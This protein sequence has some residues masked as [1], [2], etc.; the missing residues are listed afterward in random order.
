MFSTTLVIIIFTVVIQG[1]ATIPLLH[2]LKI[3]I[4]VNYA[5]VT[6][7]RNA[8]YE[9]KFLQFDNKY[10]QP[11]FTNKKYSPPSDANTTLELSVLN[12]TRPDSASSGTNT[13]LDISVE[14]PEMG[15]VH[16]EDQEPS[17][18]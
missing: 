11:F 1:G 16:L 18:N 12:Q 9:D 5:E 8:R 7:A 13:S 2:Y 10:L 6:A 3:P 15:V 14:H 4:G 17:D